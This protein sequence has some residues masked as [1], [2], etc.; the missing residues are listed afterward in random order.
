MMS[1]LPALARLTALLAGAMLLALAGCASTAEPPSPAL[2]K[3]FAPGG[4]LRAAINLGNPI[5][6]NRAPGATEPHGISVDL[7]RELGRRLGVPVE[8]VTFTSAGRTVDAATAALVDI[9]FVA[10]DP[11]R[12]AGMGQTAPYVVIEGAY[13]VRDESPIRH[14]AEV[15]RAGHRVIVATGS[16]YDLF[17]T[18]EL[19]AAQLV[20]IGTSQQVADG[21]LAQNLEVAA[22]VRQ[23]MQMDADR[24]NRTQP[25][26]RVLDGRFMVINQDMGLP[27]GRPAAQAYLD[28]FVEEMKSSGFVAQSLA[29]HRID[30]AAV[31]PP[32]CS[33]CR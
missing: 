31:A 20:R 16:A 15:D 12:G 23:Q 29:R 13:L 7:A 33:P 24:L 19:R 1:S 4:S 25:T 11:V 30:G 32:A 27:K 18:R 10:V 8:L 22:G 5:L 6:A 17:L 28:A 2:V 3:E 14:N 21:M 9:A 26:V